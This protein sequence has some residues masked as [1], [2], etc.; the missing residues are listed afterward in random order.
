MRALTTVARLGMDAPCGALG[1]CLCLCLCL[2]AGC[3]RPDPV[4]GPANASAKGPVGEAAPRPTVVLGPA[5]KSEARRIV[6]L[7]PSLTEI[8]LALD[9]TLSERLVGVTRFDD[10][11][12]VAHLPRVGGYSDPSVEAVI[13]LGPDLVL[14]EAGPGNRQAVERVAARGVPTRAFFLGTRAEILGAIEEVAQLVG[15]LEKG[16]TLK[17]DIERRIAALSRSTRES[18]EGAGEA[19]GQ[20]APRALVVYGWE[21]IVAA[22]PGTFADEIVRLAGGQNAIEST[23]IQYPALTPEALIALSPRVIVDAAHDRT[24]SRRHI[25]EWARKRGVHMSEASPA[26]LRPGV[27]LADAVEELHRAMRSVR[28]PEIPAQSPDVGA[29]EGR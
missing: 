4:N 28:S 1:L 11:P 20:A 19:S 10:D 29:Q 7:A 27:R 14:A 5:L 6:S 2:A 9:P 17:A 8:A 22:G 13:A 12:A 23:A 15:R 24:A 26:L 16:R 25:V 3:A 21:P 18:M